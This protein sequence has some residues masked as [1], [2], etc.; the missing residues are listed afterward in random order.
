MILLISVYYVTFEDNKNKSLKNGISGLL[1]S[2]L[3]SVI[4][5]LAGIDEEKKVNEITKEEREKIVHTLKNLE[6]NITGSRR[7]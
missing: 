1:P 7:L 5:L 6:I 2:K 4:P 3:I